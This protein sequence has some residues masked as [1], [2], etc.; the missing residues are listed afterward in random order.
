MTSRAVL[1][2]S[3]ALIKLAYV[4]LTVTMDAPI[5][6][7]MKRLVLLIGKSQ[8]NVTNFVVVFSTVNLTFICEVFFCT[9][10]YHLVFRASD[11][12]LPRNPIRFKT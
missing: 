3:S 1:I 8:N 4:F 2:K 12:K 11:F 7:L 9:I 5:H 6:I 10:I